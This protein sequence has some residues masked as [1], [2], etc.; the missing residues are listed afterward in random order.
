[1][2]DRRYAFLATAPTDAFGGAWGALFL[3]DVHGINNIDANWA[4]T[5]TFLGMVFG[6]PLISWSSDILRSRRIPMVAGAV[7]SGLILCTL[8][9]YP[10]L[11]P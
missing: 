6:S 4:A 10:T 3:R 2:V 11:A 9:Y 8:I 7:L 5:M 1:L